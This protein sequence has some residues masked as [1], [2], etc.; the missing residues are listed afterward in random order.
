MNSRCLEAL[1]VSLVWM[2]WGFL[3]FTFLMVFNFCCMGQ[4][5]VNIERKVLVFLSMFWGLASCSVFWQGSI[6]LF[7]LLFNSCLFLIFLIAR[8]LLARFFLFFS[9]KQFENESVF[10]LAH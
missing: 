8:Y 7:L 6:F 2:N 5:Q 1:E 3:L 9:I 4:A 10:Y